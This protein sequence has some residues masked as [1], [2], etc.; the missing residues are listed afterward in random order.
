MNILI[1][2]LVALLCLVLGYL[3]GSAN[4]S[5]PLGKLL[6]NQDPRDYGSHNCGA[7][8]CGRIWGKKY[9][10]IVFFFDIFKTISPLF[11]C[12]AIL[13]FAP[14]NNGTPL[15]PSA[16]EMYTADLSSYVIKWPVYWLASFGSLL[17]GLFPLFANF[18]G[19]KAVS[20]LAGLIISTSWSM[21]IVAISTFLITLFKTKFVSLSSLIAGVVFFVFIWLYSSLFTFHLIPAE[22]MFVFQNGSLLYCN[23][24]F[25]I[26][27]SVKIIIMFV[28]HH[29]NIARLKAG[30]EKQVQWIK[31][32]NK[33]SN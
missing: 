11:I 10:F 19:G 31:S 20:A 27:T 26:V 29:Q 33:V 21:A 14:L 15:L 3:I 28:R 4:I 22:M 9:F 5:I 16:Y 24:V 13:T 2:I 18:R 6:F 23:Y 12:W 17:G 25:A 7:T 1:N 8:N 32:K 30:T